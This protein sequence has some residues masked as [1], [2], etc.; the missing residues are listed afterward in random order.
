MPFPNP[1][2]T[3]RNLPLQTCKLCA[4]ERSRDHVTA[5]SYAL[6]ETIRPKITIHKRTTK[7]AEKS[8]FAFFPFRIA[9]T[10]YRGKKSKEATSLTEN[11]IF[12]PSSF[13]RFFKPLVI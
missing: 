10:A 2:P 12:S 7:K 11:F 4:S 6:F 13:V 1:H 8:N 9:D 5:G 3:H